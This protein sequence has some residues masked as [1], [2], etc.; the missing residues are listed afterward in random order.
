L[1]L[2]GGEFVLCNLFL[3]L[4][5][6]DGGRESTAPVTGITIQAF[7]KNPCNQSP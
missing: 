5:D 2:G 1:N 4:P 6:M 7:W 3:D